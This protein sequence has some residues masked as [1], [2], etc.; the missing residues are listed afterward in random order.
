MLGKTK[1]LIIFVI[2]NYKRIIVK[3][4]ALWKK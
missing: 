1:F 3:K 4:Y 2:Y